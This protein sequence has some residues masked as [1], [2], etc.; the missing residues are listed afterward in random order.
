MAS[1]PD[2]LATITP[3]TAVFLDEGIDDE[4]VELDIDPGFEQHLGGD[5]LDRFRIERGDLVVADTR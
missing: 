5:E 4:G 2:L 3:A 1:R